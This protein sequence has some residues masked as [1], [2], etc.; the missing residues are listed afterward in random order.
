MT[1]YAA[2]QVTSV[3]L[4]AYAERAT[5]GPGTFALTYAGRTDTQTRSELGARFDHT[6]L[7]G[8]AALKLSGR[9]AWA[10]NFER[11]SQFTQATFQALPGASF[12]V[13]GAIPDRDSLLASAGAEIQ[14]AN[15]LSVGATFE[16]EFSGNLASYAGKGT[17]RY[18]W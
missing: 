5:V 13:G 10:H 7:T 9:A 16:G 8:E 6:M 18:E 2:L 12:L 4:P 11:G 1:P 15:G 3:R 17:I 14:W